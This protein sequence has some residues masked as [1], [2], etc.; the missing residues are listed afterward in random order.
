MSSSGAGKEAKKGLA[1]ENLYDLARVYALG[2]ASPRTEKTAAEEFVQNA[3]A[4]LTRLEDAG[5]FGTKTHMERARKDDDLKALR[6][7]EEFKS[8]LERAEKQIRS[9]PAGAQP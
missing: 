4:L 7:R 5:Y 8:I 9:A 2:A 3:L 1:A 6:E